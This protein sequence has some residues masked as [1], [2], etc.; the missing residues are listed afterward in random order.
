MLG[1]PN[2]VWTPGEY[3]ARNGSPAGRTPL[4]ASNSSVSSRI[5]AER[6]GHGSCSF[7][8]HQVRP[9]FRVCAP[10]RAVNQVSNAVGSTGS[11]GLIVSRLSSPR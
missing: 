8:T 4:A 7:G 10:Q 1:R 6:S 2:R 3:N 11:P 9:A 5:V